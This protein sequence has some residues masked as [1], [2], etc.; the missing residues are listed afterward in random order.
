[1]FK[2]AN[3]V[4][5]ETLQNEMEKLSEENEPK[6]LAPILKINE[7]MN[8]YYVGF[9]TG[10][11][12]KPCR[13]VLIHYNPF[14]ICSRTDPDYKTV[15]GKEEFVVDNK[16]WECPRCQ[17]SWDSYVEAGYKKGMSRPLPQ[18]LEDHK[19]NYYKP[20]LGFAKTLIQAID[21]TPFF[22]ATGRKKDTPKPKA[23]LIKKW[24][25]PFCDVLN[26]GEVPED[27]PE[28]IA[29]AAQSGMQIM[30]VPKTVGLAFHDSYLETL[31]EANLDP[32]THPDEM[33]LVI[34]KTLNPLKQV[35]TADG[36]SRAGGEYTATFSNKVSGWVSSDGMVDAGFVSYVESQ[37]KDLLNLESDS[38]DLKE[39]ARSLVALSEDEMRELLASD[40]THFWSESE[41][42]NSGSQ[43]V[44]EASP[45]TKSISNS[46][47]S[48][49][50]VDVLDE[51][52]P[53]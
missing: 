47:M 38:D 40:P 31:E 51:E 41:R 43:S 4:T 22:E 46:A 26:G 13:H 29:K 20:N 11:M 8:V 9:A 44:A 50:S 25:K 37:V 17:K 19:N 28:D 7:G 1:M 48:S 35:E 42:L 27:M 30:V 45:V 53:F 3:T 39:K 15:N 5:Y 16:F 33:L 18:S 12:T 34:N 21:L 32:T 24:F 2:K 23:D 14:H 6:Q 10:A 49:G 36:Q 52:I